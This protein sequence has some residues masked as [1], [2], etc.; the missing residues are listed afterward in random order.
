MWREPQTRH[1]GVIEAPLPKRSPA[2]RKAHPP[3]AHDPLSGNLGILGPGVKIW[4]ANHRFEDTSRSIA[5]QGYEYK[6][7]T[8]GNHVWIGANAFIMP[9]AAIG[10]YVVISA[11]AVVG[12]KTYPPYKIVAGNPARVIGTRESNAESDQS[13]AE[14]E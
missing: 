4:S 1:Q 6:K 9:G 2:R 3:G 11:G 8:I 10:D 12:A 14:K 13:P 5:E 7:V